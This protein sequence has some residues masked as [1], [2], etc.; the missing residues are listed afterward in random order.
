MTVYTLMKWQ[1]E[2]EVSRDAR[3]TYFNW[4]YQTPNTFKTEL[5]PDTGRNTSFV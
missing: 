1:R 2:P 5:L 3:S 4:H